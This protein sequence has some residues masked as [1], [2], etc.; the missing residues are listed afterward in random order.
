MPGGIT[1]TIVCGS[2]LKRT[3]WPIDVGARAEPLPPERRR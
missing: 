1:P 3:V 2:S